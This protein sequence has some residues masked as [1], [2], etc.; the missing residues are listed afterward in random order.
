M[1]LWLLASV[2]FSLT[3][4]NLLFFKLLFDLHTSFSIH[5][6]PALSLKSLPGSFPPSLPRLVQVSF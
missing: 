4:L 2:Y 6:S 1:L 5:L 3:F